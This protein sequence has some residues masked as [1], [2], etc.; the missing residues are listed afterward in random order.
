MLRGRSTDSIEQCV[1]AF[2]YPLSAMLLSR[3]RFC[4]YTVANAPK[5]VRMQ[6]NKLPWSHFAIFLLLFFLFFF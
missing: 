5:I 6:L 1:N 2:T 3:A 4:E